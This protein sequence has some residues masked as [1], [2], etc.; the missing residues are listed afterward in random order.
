[1]TGR[2]IVSI[3]LP[4]FPMERWQ[5]MQERAGSTAPDDVAQVLATEGPHGPV[6][7]AANR[8]AHLAGV[9]DGARV[10]DMRALCPALRVDH[11]DPVGDRAA[12]DKLALWARRWCPWTAV[13]G[14]GLILDTTGSDH[15]WGGEAA[16]LEEMEA[17]LALI[18]LSARLALAPTWGAAWA[19]A[20]FGPV[21]AIATD[22]AP[23][24]VAALRLE[25][26]TV[27]LLNRLGLKSI[28]ALAALP[29]LALARRFQRAELAANPL[30]RLDQLT[31]HLAEPLAPP[32]APQAFVA[33]A[34]LAEPIL[35]PTHHLPGLCDALCA[36]LAGAGMG[37]RR[38]RLA[39]YRTDG[40]VAAISA[41]VA[42]PSR[43]AGH[44]AFL[45][46]DRLERI[47]PGY[48]FDLIALEAVVVEPL[49]V[50][51]ATLTGGSNAALALSH[52]V[53][54]LTTRFGAGAVARLQPR[55]SHLPERAETRAAPLVRD[56]DEPARKHRSPFLADLSRDK[57]ARAC[58]PARP[59]D[60]RSSRKTSTGR[61][62]IA[63][64]P[65]AGAL[66]R[67]PR[68]ARADSQAPVLAPRPL[69]NGVPPYGQK[70]D[71]RSIGNVHQTV[72]K[73]DE[74]DDPVK[75]HPAMAERPIRLLAPP[76]EIRVLYAVPEGP[77]AQFLWRRQTHR[78]VRYAGPERIAPEWWQDQ[79]GTRLR[80]YFKVEDAAG[81]RYWLY[82]EG[83]HDDGRGGDP[84]WFLHGI[85]T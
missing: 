20:R 64:H 16:M 12:L 3:F 65:P 63:H 42:T 24:P 2:R 34:R 13:D 78:T 14:Q 56:Q 60:G 11:A 38:V 71:E 58:H 9:T 73:K 51:Q 17:R 44:L 46:R 47:D 67:Q 84:R 59:R 27:L 53:D 48:G 8:A 55:Q 61:F 35:D 4:Q 43:D 7:H 54:R 68:Q 52:L 22:P 36:E 74:N 45:F 10:V 76:E 32:D 50:T 26:E 30:L 33:I 40:E 23:L 6:V 75:D 57:S 77:P 80:D 72:L 81:R 69:P 70:T 83:L 62:L 1:M 37:A 49:G 82:R 21:R 28:G 18:G 29:R 85:F 19:L 39:V 66:P 5:K 41:A 31:G 25:P 79:P 15:L